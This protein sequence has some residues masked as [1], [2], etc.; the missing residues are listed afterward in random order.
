VNNNGV[1]GSN[2]AG[3]HTIIH[4]VP[5]T[6]VTTIAGY[7]QIFSGVPGGLSITTGMTTVTTPTIP[8]GGDTQLYSLTGTGVLS[9]LT[10]SSQNT[11]GYAWIGGIL[12]QWGRLDN[13]GS[14]AIINFNV[15]NV[16]F[17]T[18]CFNVQ[19]T[20]RFDG[21]IVPTVFSLNGL[22]TKTSFTY[23]TNSTTAN[24]LFWIAI[25]N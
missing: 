7:N 8:P 17:P 11:N 12:I 24:S 20:G 13:P 4:Q 22:P 14:G 1:P 5:Q 2:P 3:Y 25:G 15:A 21:L 9:Q 23:K 19:L 10:G 6:N 16:N 18:N